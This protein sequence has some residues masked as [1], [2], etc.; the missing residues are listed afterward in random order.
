M[1]NFKITYYLDEKGRK[2][3]LSW[4]VRLDSLAARKVY[5]TLMRMEAGNFSDS[6]YLKGGVWEK[7]IHWG[8]GYRLY[9]GLER[10]GFVIMLAGGTK[11]NQ[12]AD[13][14]TAKRY[15]H[16]YKNSKR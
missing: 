16:E 1:N 11:K 15:W 14:E 3:F 5:L 10:R 9:Y 2:P 4:Y 13:I 8:P 12:Q 7:R 6:K